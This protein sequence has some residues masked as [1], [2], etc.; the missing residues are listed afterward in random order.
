[1]QDLGEA[2]IKGKS[3]CQ[4]EVQDHADA[5]PVAGLGKGLLVGLLWR[6]K[7]GCSGDLDLAEVEFV[8]AEFGDKPE[9]EDHDATFGGDEDI[10]R[11]EIAMKEAHA[12]E[13]I[14]AL[15][16]LAQGVEESIEMER[17]AR[18]GVR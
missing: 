4:G 12:V 13:G 7:G 1:M 11:F 16:E 15:G 14:D 2:S 18:F 17:E 10:G 3:A 5:I 6:H 8:L 9:V